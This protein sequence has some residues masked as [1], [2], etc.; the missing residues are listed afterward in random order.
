METQSLTTWLCVRQTHK[1]SET[2]PEILDSTGTVGNPSSWGKHRPHTEL[3]AYYAKVH[4]SLL[5]L[6]INPT[7]YENYKNVNK[8]HWSHSPSNFVLFLLLFLAD[9]SPMET[10]C[11]TLC[12]THSQ[13]Q[14]DPPTMGIHSLISNSTG[15][16]GNPNSWVKRRPHTK[17]A[18]KFANMSQISPYP[19]GS[20]T[21]SKAR[22]SLDSPVSWMNP[23]SP[24][25]H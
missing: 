17:F 6:H 5:C 12:W 15:T 9:N 21:P 25:S 24:P 16:M 11:L 20:D 1:C 23:K 3:E 2:H 7:W 13:M 14:W 18:V 8:Y 10:Y 19:P 22:D 4:R